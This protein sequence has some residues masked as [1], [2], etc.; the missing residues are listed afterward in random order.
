MENRIYS[1]TELNGDLKRLIEGRRDLI[2]IWVRGEV[3]DCRRSPNQHIYFNLKDENSCIPC[4]LFRSDAVKLSFRLADGMAVVAFGSVAVYLKGG[5]YQLKCS[6]VMADGVGQLQLAFEQLKERLEKEGLFDERHKKPL[7]RFPERI[8]LITAARGDAVRDMIRI[9]GSRWP[10]TKV[11][12]MSVPVQGAEAAP[13]LVGAI[14]YA[15]EFKVADLLIV[16]RGGGSAEDLW[17]YNDERVARA[18]YASDI[19]VISAVGHEPDVLISDY[20][21]DRRASTPSNAAEIAVPDQREL[22][23]RLQDYAVRSARAMDR[24]LGRFSDRL[25]SLSSRRVLTGPGSF[26]DDR[27][28]TLERSYER[29]IAAQ[30]RALT[31]GKQRYV[32][33]AAALDAMSPLRVLARG[34][35]AAE[36]E[37]GGAVS[38]ATRLRP[39]D[40]LRLRFAD[41]QAKCTVDEVYNYGGERTEF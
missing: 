31:A 28:L 3:S 8:A 25:D 29:L 37:K 2:N 17:S 13:A 7:P 14:K 32:R 23:K 36:D 15:N 34:Y 12:V 5:C 6:T 20:V 4:T 30:D 39:G 41:G 35:A 9:L 1:V 27:R 22:R 26:I 19:P 18:I 40:R 24:Q 10:M 38:S 21:A 16:G 11:L 33:L